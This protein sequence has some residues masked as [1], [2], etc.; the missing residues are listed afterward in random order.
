M[1]D[2]S[3]EDTNTRHK[4]HG[5]HKSINCRSSHMKR[6]QTTKQEA[7]EDEE[8]DEEE[9]KKSPEQHKMHTDVDADTDGHREEEEQVGR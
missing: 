9:D 6:L 4:S 5:G 7:T 2:D 1:S 8:E 3:R